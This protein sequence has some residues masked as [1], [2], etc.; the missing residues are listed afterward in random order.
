MAGEAPGVAVVGDEVWVC[1]VERLF[2]VSWVVLI[3]GDWV[4]GGKEDWDEAK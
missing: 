2:V 4:E 3:E 1:R